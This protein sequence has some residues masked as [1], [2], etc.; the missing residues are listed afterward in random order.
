MLSWKAFEP[1]HLNRILNKN[2]RYIF[3]VLIRVFR[4]SGLA[5]IILVKLEIFTIRPDSANHSALLHI[6]IQF[7]FFT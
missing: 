6:K 1:P 2:K 3:I 4:N 5:S 7:K